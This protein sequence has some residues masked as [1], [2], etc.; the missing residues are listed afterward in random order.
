M[1][2]ITALASS[3]A[4]AALPT[5]ASVMTDRYT[6][7]MAEKSAR[8]AQEAEW[9]HEEELAAAERQRVLEALGREQEV[10]SSQLRA[11]QAEAYN[12]AKASADTTLARYQAESDANERLRRT[13]LRRAMASTRATLGAQGVGTADG[14]GEAILLGLVSETGAERREATTSDALRRRVVQEELDALG[15]RNLLEQAQ[16]AER[17]RLEILSSLS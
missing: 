15:R 1:S 8:E 5:A 12:T 2:G 10:E 6:T 4:T 17:Q 11:T 13:A 9:R 7:R 16:L 3:L 14:S